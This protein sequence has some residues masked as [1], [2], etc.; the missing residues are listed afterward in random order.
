M[1]MPAAS[2]LL[3]NHDDSDANLVDIG[4]AT[5]PGLLHS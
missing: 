3:A 4:I 2:I 1:M 5:R